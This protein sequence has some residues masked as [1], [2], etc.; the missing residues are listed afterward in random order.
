[1]RSVSRACEFYLERKSERLPLAL[2]AGR[3]AVELELGRVARRVLVLESIR[4][5]RHVE[6]ALEQRDGPAIRNKT[7]GR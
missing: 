2:L 1:M 7:A 3:Q 4:V 5:V 6:R